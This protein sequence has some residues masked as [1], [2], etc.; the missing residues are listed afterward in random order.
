MQ[1]GWD[2]FATIKDDLPPTTLVIGDVNDD[3]DTSVVDV[4]L[5][6]DKILGMNLLQ[7]NPYTADVNKDGATDVVDVMTIVGLVLKKNLE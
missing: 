3:G 6:V 2:K 1:N 4:M 7:Y 5:L